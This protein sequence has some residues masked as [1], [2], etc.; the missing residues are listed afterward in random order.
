MYGGRVSLIVGFV[1]VFFELIIGV[2]IGGVSGYFGGV[3]D[4]ILMRFVEL[5]NAIPFYPMLI[6]LGSVMDTPPTDAYT[7]LMLTMVIGGLWHGANWTFVA[8]G[9]L[10]GAARC[11]HKLWARW[12]MANGRTGAS[13]FGRLLSVVLTFHWAAFCFVFFRANSIQTALSMLSGIFTMRPG[14]THIS[15]WA[16]ISLLLVGLASLAAVLRSRK[17]GGIPDGYYPLQDL[18]SI[19]GLTLF[20]TFLGLTLLLG[21]T[22]QSPFIYF[23]F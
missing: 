5:F 10:H 14:V 9:A 18:G 7:R 23:Q 12:R 19:R 16:V 6:I 21:Y 1:V 2:I 8:W 15:F 20:F 13:A 17:T 11:V 22:G 3:V 4:T